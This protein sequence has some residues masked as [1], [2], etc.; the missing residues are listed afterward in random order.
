MVVA[1]HVEEVVELQIRRCHMNRHRSHLEEVVVDLDNSLQSDVKYN[2]T[3]LK[4]GTRSAT[5][6]PFRE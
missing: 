5:K 3:V 1:S 2:Q 6:I 4:S